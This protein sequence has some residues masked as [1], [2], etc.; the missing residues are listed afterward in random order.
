MAIANPVRICR[1]E[2]VDRF[3]WNFMLDSEQIPGLDRQIG[4]ATLSDVEARLGW[5]FV[6]E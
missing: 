1:G 4:R 6:A 5:P 3:P 2:T